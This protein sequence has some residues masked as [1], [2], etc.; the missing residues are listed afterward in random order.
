MR[1]ITNLKTWMVIV[2]ILLGFGCSIAAGEV[3][4]VDAGRPTGGD[5]QAWSTAYKYL[6][7]ALYKPAIS[8]DEIWVAQGTYRPDEDEGGN[9]TPGDRTATFQLI[10]GVE[11]C[12][13]FASGGGAWG[14]RDPN[15]YET[16]LSGDLNGD[17]IVIA[18]PCDLLNEPTRAENSYH[19]VY[20]NGVDETTVLDGFTITAGNANGSFPFNCGGGMFNWD[21]SHPTVTNCTFS[22]NLAGYGGGMWNRESNPTLSNCTFSGNSAAKDG[23]G[24]YNEDNSNPTLT[25]CTFSGNSATI[26]GGGMYNR[27]KSNATVTGCTFSGNSA[28][29]DGGGMSNWQSSPTVTN[30]TFSGNSAGWG[31]GIDNYDSDPNITNCTFSG[32][33]ATEGAAGWTTTTATRL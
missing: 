22:G 28:D 33:S 20:T 17:D 32:N 11:I 5:G 26:R 13:G 30:C 9:V 15:A 27:W 19:V 7:D 4:Y 29:E 21:N 25:D 18:D 6:Q 10:S 24:M 3:I 1:T 8:G 14:D 31:G 23:G 12:G 2:V 16:K